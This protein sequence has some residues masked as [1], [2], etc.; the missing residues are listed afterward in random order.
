MIYAKIDWYTVLLYNR[1]FKDILEKLN[2]FEDVCDDILNSGYQ[3]SVGYRTDVVYSCNGVSLSVKFDDML[4]IEEEDIF[5]AKW[6]EVRLDISGTG[7]DYLRTI[8][9]FFDKSMCDIDFWGP[10]GTF[11]ITRCD[12]AFDFVNFYPS[13]LDE[14][15]FKLQDLERADILRRRNDG[16]IYLGTL[17][18]V[19][20]RGRNVAYNINRGTK[21]NCLYL[22][23]S[24]SDKLVRI[25]DKKLEQSENGVFKK[26]IP[27]CFVKNGDGNVGSWFRIEFQT[28]R[29]FAY[30]YLFGCNGNL[31][32]VLREL[33]K[34]YQCKDP[35]TNQ[36]FD[37]IKKLYDWDSLPRIIDNLHFI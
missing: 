19:D 37:C 30:K 24:R 12:F 13:F 29:K 6:Q 3:R 35:E 14:F 22:G 11:K 10:E 36:V 25:Y 4:G 7:L 16:N 34:L 5:F 18:G 1:S 20:G 9:Q 31:K 27:E 32:S 33:F 15:I 23:T 21:I 26:P 28:R 17:N 2:C 8:N